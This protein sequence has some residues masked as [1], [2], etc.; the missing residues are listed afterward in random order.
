[1]DIRMHTAQLHLPTTANKDA[2]ISATSPCPAQCSDKASAG[3]PVIITCDFHWPTA[4]T[5]GSTAPSPGTEAAARVFAA[6][7]RS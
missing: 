5:A 4:K 6:S 7:A 2:T 3:I 1:M